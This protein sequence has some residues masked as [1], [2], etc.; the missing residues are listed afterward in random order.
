MRVVGLDLGTQS[1]KAVVC[2]E[3]LAVLGHPPVG[4]PTQY[5]G[6]GGARPDPRGGGAGIGPAIAGALAAA[7]AR[8][9]AIAGL[10]IAGQ[11]DGCVAVDAHGAPLH[12]ALIWQD[13][14][15]VADAA[16]VDARRLF[17]LT[18]QVADAGHMAPKLRWL[19]RGGAGGGRGF[20]PGGVLGGGGGRGG[21][22]GSGGGAAPA[23]AG[24]GGGRGG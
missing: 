15:A 18:G 24:A 19:R 6:P 16:R 3:A 22:G 10:A 7:G 23:P 21:G 20:P 11:L 5:P 9:E 14:R 12:P 13:R 2:D 1:L 17:A 8:P 4:Y